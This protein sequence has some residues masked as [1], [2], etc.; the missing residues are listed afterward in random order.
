MMT[1]LITGTPVSEVTIPTATP[2]FNVIY[3]FSCHSEYLNMPNIIL[4]DTY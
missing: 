4:N 3:S 1:H 2:V